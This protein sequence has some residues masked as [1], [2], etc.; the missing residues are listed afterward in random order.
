MVFLM[1]ILILQLKLTFKVV[2]SQEENIL[3][4]T[5]VKNIKKFIEKS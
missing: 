1:Y 4:T 2:L 3:I 5:F